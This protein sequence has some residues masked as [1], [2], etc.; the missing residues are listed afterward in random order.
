MKV[1]GFPGQGSQVRGMGATLFEKYR[2]LTGTASAVLGYSI[3]ELCLR[4]P[5]KQLDKTQY[6]QP[7]LYV[8]SAFAYLDARGQGREADYLIGHSLGELGALFA[9]GAYSFENGLE[10]VAKRGE[11]MSRASGGAMAAVL[12][13]SEEKIKATLLEHDLTEIDIANYNAPNQI[14]ISGSK[15][16]IARAEN[17]FKGPAVRYIPLN[18]SGAF[19]SRWMRDAE[20]EF[21][22]FL[23]RYRFKTIKTPV[24]ST[25]TAKPYK[26]DEIAHNL[27]KQLTSPVR[28]TDGIGYLLAQG[29][30]EFEEI[31]GGGVLTKLVNA[32]RNEGPRLDARPTDARRTENGN[33]GDAPSPSEK[34]DRWNRLYPVGTK[35]KSRVV[36]EDGLETRTEAIVLFGCRAAVYLKGLDGYFD[37]EELTPL[38]S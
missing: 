9:A 28:W 31:G 16:H 15:D 5:Q 22:E 27:T 13:C 3:E 24:V 8:V 6:T 12:N 19:H 4:D 25:Y 23:G 14:V 10:I 33:R 2:E 21:R 11:L 38:A 32:I 20:G 37:L 36:D 17:C 18:T 26:Q 29:G 30:V 1:Y 35:V 7:A 34:V